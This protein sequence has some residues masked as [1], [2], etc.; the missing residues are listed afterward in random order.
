MKKE[1]KEKAYYITQYANYEFDEDVYNNLN[2]WIK[3]NEIDETLLL[4]LFDIMPSIRDSINES[5]Y[6]VIYTL[7]NEKLEKIIEMMQAIKDNDMNT[8]ADLVNNFYDW[9]AEQEIY[10][11]NTLE[12]I[13]DEDLKTNGVKARCLYWV[14]EIDYNYNYNQ[15][16]GYYNGFH[17]LNDEDVI[18]LWACDNF[19]SWLEEL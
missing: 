4:E 13:A 6:N 17:T 16:N 5:I 19:E 12:E 10:D 7:D 9:M 14:N 1:L 8:I 18:D 2:C 11:P 3:E 15:F